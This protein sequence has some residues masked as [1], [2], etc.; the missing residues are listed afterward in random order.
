MTKRAVSAS[1]PGS[2]WDELEQA[3][4][5]GTARGVGEPQPSSN[6]DAL[7][8]EVEQKDLRRLAEH[9]RLV[10]SHNTPLGNIVFLHGI[11]GSD[12]AV[13]SKGDVDD[14]WINIPRLVFGKIELLKLAADGHLEANPKLTVRATR[15]NK[16]YY[17]KAVLA[18]RAR[19]N[20]EPYA[21]D[22]RKDID[23][24]SDG[25]ANLIR[26]KFPG[27]SVHL[28]AHSLGGLVARNFIRRHPDLWAQMRDSELTAGGRLVM[29]GTPNYGSYA[30][31]SV[32]TG[33]E[34]SMEMLALV[35]I[36]H[37]MSELLSITNTFLGSYMLLPAPDKLPTRLASL[38]QKDTWGE[39]PGIAQQHLNRTYQFHHDLANSATI[40]SARM[41]YV[42]GC[43][44]ATISSM[45]IVAPG[46]FEYSFTSA[47]DG[48]VPH[49]LGLLPG[50]PTYYVDEVHGDLARN[51]KVLRAVD[52]ILAT[53]A[54]DELS[55]SVLRAREVA[56]PK[57]RDY[58]TAADRLLIGDMER[59]AIKI[60]EQG[61]QGELTQ[62]EQQFAADALLK[63]AMGSGARSLPTALEPTDAVARRPYQTAA[64]RKPIDLEVA[65]RYGDVKEIP[66]QAIVVG[67]YRG[68]QPVNAIGAIDEA[69][70]GW[71]SRAVKR[72]M[73]SGHLGE[74]FYI[75]SLEHIEANGVVVAG[76]GDYGRFNAGALRQLMANVAIGAVG[77]GFTSIAG[78]L[79]GAGE[80]G[81]DCDIALRELIE[82]LGTGLNEWREED[83]TDE[84]SL[85]QLVLIERSPQRFF[86]LRRLL[87]TIAKT[88]SLSTVNLKLGEP[89]R[90]DERKARAD[91][92]RA[93]REATKPNAGLSSLGTAE[94]SASFNEFDEVRI[95]VECVEERSVFRFS[96]LTR[97]AVVPV[98]EVE[99]NLRNAYEAADALRK[100]RTRDEQ[101]LFGQLF[102]T[103]LIPQDF[104]ELIDGPFPVRLIVDPTSASFPWEMA[105]FTARANAARCSWLGPDLGLS[106]Q[107]KT[108]LSSAPGISPPRNAKLRV[109]VIADPAPEPQLE[110]HGARMEGR[111]VVDLLRRANG[112]VFDNVKLDIDV[113][114]RIG[115][116]ECEPME[117]LALLLSGEFDIVHFSG[118][119]DYNPKDPNASGWIF[120][121]DRV[122]TA[123][124]IFR[125]RK[126]PR[127]VF[128]NACFSGVLRESEA[129]APQSISRGLASIAE[130]FLERGVPNYVGTGW[131]VDDSQAV[132]MAHVFYKALLQ[133][134]AIG[135]A[136]KAGSKAVFDEQVESTWGAY[137]LYGNPGDTVLGRSAGMQRDVQRS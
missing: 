48:R 47:G 74:T 33:T 41:V 28:V 55:T 126:V 135:G 13:E 69:L 128:A 38:Y 93:A 22:W 120:G 86:K 82:G 95:T 118:H 60:K 25:L 50:V 84:V 101:Q 30:I 46:E 26:D 104:H 52:A 37:N 114:S 70:H 129:Y 98:R 92:L 32:L 97:S 87:Q 105:C 3:L 7:F 19:W 78:V 59:L 79:V 133:G 10:R 108:L 134:K 94:L 36:P 8:D 110:L 35:D 45:E 136:L 67:H 24:A 14:I 54:T 80:G 63:A 27:K 68:V 76:M 109:L 121:A 75:P 49:E 64:L 103:Y 12:L 43:R 42:A 117:M 29:L 20:V 15:I 61:E 18:L 131:P 96:A 72:G 11:T 100:A 5:R 17:A 58:R 53:G 112:Q 34:Q 65:L 77:M 137:Q 88:G 107:F 119:G 73:I 44:R 99:V 123:R 4:V 102:Y 83:G 1:K 57:M 6:L 111:M 56:P 132:K 39:T 31:P 21:Y 23:E 9:S 116:G 127:L 16:K 91:A 106:R 71:I 51:E 122:L 81:L 62:V 40:D 66:A 2:E 124:D 125:A 89:L 130:A 85:K 90:A 113:V 115:P